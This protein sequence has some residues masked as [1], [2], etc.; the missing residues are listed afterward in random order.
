MLAYRS[1]LPTDPLSGQGWA[2]IDPK[3]WPVELLPELQEYEATHPDGTPI[4]NDMLF[5]GFLIYF[6]PGLRVFIDD[7]CELYGDDKVLAYV[8]AEPSQ[9]EEWARRYQFNIALTK[10]ESSYNGYLNQA[11]GWSIVKRTSAA[12]LYRRSTGGFR[13]D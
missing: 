12:I 6:T 5:G 9:F 4:F 1:A 8:K 7:R 2:R 11:Q 10:S 3:H 13:Q